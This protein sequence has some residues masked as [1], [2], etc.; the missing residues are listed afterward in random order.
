MA[1]VSLGALS[2]PFLMVGIVRLRKV[3]FEH[4]FQPET[5]KTI[6]L[7]PEARAILLKGKYNGHTDDRF[8]LSAQ[9]VP[10]H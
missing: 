9:I 8:I 10:P 1:R 2:T 7:L 3:T 5:D 6:P 4:P